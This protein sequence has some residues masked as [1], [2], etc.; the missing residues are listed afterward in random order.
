MSRCRRLVYLLLI[1]I[2]AT[3][4]VESQQKVLQN[5]GNPESAAVLDKPVSDNAHTSPQ[6]ESDALRPITSTVT[7]RDATLVD[8]RAADAAP[9][10]TQQATPPA[11]GTAN[12]GAD[13]QTA[14]PVD[15]TTK[16]AVDTPAAVETIAKEKGDEQ[17]GPAV[18][19]NDNAA[20]PTAHPGETAEATT[21]DADAYISGAK[22]LMAQQPEGAVA[23]AY[24]GEAM[25]QERGFF[26]DL[27]Q[28]IL[29]IIQTDFNFLISSGTIFSSLLTQLIPL[30]TV[31]TIRWNKSTGSLKTLNFV[32]VA[33]ANFLWSLYGVLSYNMVIIL[34]SL[35]GLLLNCCYIMVFHKYCKDGQQKHILHVSYKVFAASCLVLACAYLGVESEPYLKFIGLFGGSIQAFSYIAPLLSIREIMKNKSTSA[36]PTEISLANFIGSFFTLCY[37]FIIW[38]YIVIAPNFIG[39]VSGIVQITLLILIPNNEQIVVTEVGILEKQHFKPIL[40][41]EVDI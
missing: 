40:K 38:D 7:I 14:T 4:L 21:H 3:N 26:R 1:N 12:G 13:A 29:E 37:G 6:A 10:A 27:V 15:G 33:F 22:V 11:D 30:H 9:N 20:V 24:N 25:S 41:P 35:P 16:E 34:S 18:N 32:T 8:G 39:M 23:S 2:A 36:M 5:T 17:P 31:M 28:G 19:A